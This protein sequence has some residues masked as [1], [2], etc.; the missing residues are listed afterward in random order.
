MLTI[1]SQASKSRTLGN[2]ALIQDDA[3]VM[4]ETGVTSRIQKILLL[5]SPRV[6]AS[7]LTPCGETSSLPAYTRKCNMPE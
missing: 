5:D 7:D 6:P 3:C 1:D 4:A 2:H